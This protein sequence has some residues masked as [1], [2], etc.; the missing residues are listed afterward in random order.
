[1]ETVEKTIDYKLSNND[2][3]IIYLSTIIG[4]AQIGATILTIE[5]NQFKLKE[6]ENFALG[7]TSTLK[8]KNI[9][10]LTKVVDINPYNNHTIITHSLS[11]GQSTENFPF[12]KD[13]DSENGIVQ[14]KITVN[15]K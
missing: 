15:L 13:A 2:E 8:G 5:K 3:T 1:M 14:Y 9:L 6:V 4:N 11:G 10:I 7:K 12:S